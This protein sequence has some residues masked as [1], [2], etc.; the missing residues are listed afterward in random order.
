MGKYHTKWLLPHATIGYV[1]FGLLTVQPI[2]GFVHHAIFKRRRA[3]ALASGHTDSKPPGRTIL[4]H[5]HIWIG[6]TCIALVLINGGIGIRATWH[7]ANPL[8]SEGA[9]R[10][11]AIIYGTCSGLVFLLYAG[12][13]IWYAR[14]RTTK[15]ETTETMTDPL[16]E[17]AKTQAAAEGLVKEMLH[18]QDSECTTPPA[19]EKSEP[20]SV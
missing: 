8:Q 15:V 13:S 16:V 20:L 9:S 11:A 19:S 14:H 7:K 5:A 3:A 4:A 2:L 12:M 10:V 1:V 6:R 17:S 18:K